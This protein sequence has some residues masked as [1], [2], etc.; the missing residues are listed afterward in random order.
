MPDFIEVNRTC[1]RSAPTITGS[2]ERLFQLEC[3]VEIASLECQRQ[4][5]NVVEHRAVSLRFHPDVTVD[6]KVAKAN[7]QVGG[8][9]GM[10]PRVPLLIPHDWN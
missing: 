6:G 1:D 10:Q 2:E 5:G 8:A 9:V 4:A 3:V 7:A